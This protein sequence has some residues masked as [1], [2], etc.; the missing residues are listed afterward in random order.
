MVHR[1][2]HRSQLR[3]PA[4][5]HHVL[6]TFQHWCVARRVRLVTCRLPQDRLAECTFLGANR[7]CFIELS[8]VPTLKWLDTVKPGP[9]LSIET[10]TVAGL[11]AIGPASHAIRTGRF[12]ADTHLGADAGDRRYAVWLP[13]TLTRAG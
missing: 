11:N 9:A 3:D 8:Y 13:N 10:A 2:H 12:H 5:A 1:G 7:F 4:V 6:A